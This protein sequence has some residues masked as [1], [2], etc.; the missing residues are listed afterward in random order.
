MDKERI[1][2]QIRNAGLRATASRISVI[3]RLHQVGRPLTHSD[4]SEA[5][6]PEGFDRASIFRNL[7]DL[8]EVGLISRTDLGDH[9]WRF[10][11]ADEPT[12]PESH[13]A[14]HPHFVCIECGGVQ[15]LEAVEVSVKSGRRKAPKAVVRR[16]VEINFRGYCDACIA[17]S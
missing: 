13:Y 6:V 2:Q 9:V 12:R 14:Q 16:D 8:T 3:E 1:R 10:Y 7:T 4:L 11:A 17:A 15:C 5:L